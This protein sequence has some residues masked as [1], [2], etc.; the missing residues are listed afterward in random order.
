MKFFVPEDF[1]V[2]GELDTRRSPLEAA[3]YANDKLEL[4]SQIVYGNFGINNHNE[5]T[6]E[7]L[8]PKHKALLIVLEEVNLCK[9]LKEHITLSFYSNQYEP[10][11]EWKYI[12]ICGKEM[13]PKTFE[14]V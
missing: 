9:H 2:K 10:M 12:C 3:K 14:E 6:H 4:L 5:I 8:N 7:D 13:K 11:D 1:Y